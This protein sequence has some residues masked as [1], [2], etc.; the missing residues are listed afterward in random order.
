MKQIGKHPRLLNMVEP[1]CWWE[2]DLIGGYNMNKGTVVQIM[3]LEC[4]W[5]DQ[6]ILWK[7]Q[8]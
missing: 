8:A 6:A 1:A 4:T 3:C 2:T 7:T 5:R